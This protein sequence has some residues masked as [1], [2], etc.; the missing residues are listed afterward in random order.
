MKVAAA[1]QYSRCTCN[2]RWRIILEAT[3]VTK[4]TAAGAGAHCFLFLINDDVKLFF[5]SF[6]SSREEAFYQ[7]N[8]LTG[9]V[10]SEMAFNRYG[11]VNRSF[12][13]SS[14]DGNLHDSSRQSNSDTTM[15]TEQRRIAPM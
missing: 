14:S 5:S 2:A 6:D 12:V 11:E 7:G 10:D 1:N 8:D 13:V 3:K 4:E 9:S 15:M